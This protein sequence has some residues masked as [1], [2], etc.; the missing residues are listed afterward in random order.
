MAKNM[1]LQEEFKALE[2][3]SDTEDSD[4]FQ[5]AKKRAKNYKKEINYL[6]ASSS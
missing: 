5:R 2:S 6:S 1:L 3:D 4:W